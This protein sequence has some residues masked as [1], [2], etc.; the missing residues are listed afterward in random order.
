M[1]TVQA[2]A[3]IT[4]RQQLTTLLLP[5]TGLIHSFDFSILN[6]A[7]P[8]LRPDVGFSVPE[9]PRVISA[10][11]LPGALAATGRADRPRGHA[12]QRVDSYPSR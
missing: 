8:R 1:T 7:L 6:V 11:A 3:K 10:Y 5:G 4:A 12:A 2:S 9:L